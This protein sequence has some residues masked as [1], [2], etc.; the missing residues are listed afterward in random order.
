MEDFS[1]TKDS[2]AKIELDIQIIKNILFGISLLDPS[3]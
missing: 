3:K 2:F 1:I